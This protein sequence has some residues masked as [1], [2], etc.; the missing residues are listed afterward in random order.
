MQS[1]IK[2][3]FKKITNQVNI[4]T[5]SKKFKFLNLQ[6]TPMNSK[7]VFL[8]VLVLVAQSS[9]GCTPNSCTTATTDAG[10]TTA[11]ATTAATT[12]TATT[13]TTT[14]AAAAGKR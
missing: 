4:Q 9:L 12:T 7:L 8:L 13:T 2:K 1:Q 14:T 11:A 5:N 10:A 6:E 3:I